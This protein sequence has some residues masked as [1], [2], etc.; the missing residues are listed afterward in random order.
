MTDTPKIC[1]NCKY[2]RRGAGRGSDASWSKGYCDI[3][4]PV[5]PGSNSK[6]TSNVRHKIRRLVV[7]VT[8][9]CK[10]WGERG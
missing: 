2:F 7:K 8:D 1:K 6:G 10:L 9:S 4:I 3:R 5:L